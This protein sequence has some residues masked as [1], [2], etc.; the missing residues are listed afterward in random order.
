MHSQNIPALIEKNK[1]LNLFH[2]FILLAKIYF[3][4]NEPHNFSLKICIY[5]IEINLWLT[6]IS[7]VFLFVSY[8]I[9]QLLFLESANQNLKLKL[10]NFGASNLLRLNF[11]TK[12][13]RFERTTINI[14]SFM[15]LG[16]PTSTRTWPSL[17]APNR[18]GPCGTK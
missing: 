3:K 8:R 12:K 17:M 2:L 11:K 6:R 1:N 14:N 16:T 10:T 9:Y 7:Q 15:Q 18:S 5:L 13:S 4:I